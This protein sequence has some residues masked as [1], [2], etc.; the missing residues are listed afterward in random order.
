MQCHADGRLAHA[1]ARAPS[2]RSNGPR[3]KSRPPPNVGQAP[4]RQ[5]PCRSR[6][7]SAAPARARQRSPRSRRARPRCGCRGGGRRRS[8]CSGRSHRAKA[9]PRRSTRQ[10]WRFTCSA[11]SV[12]CTT[13]SGSRPPSPDP[14]AG[15]ARAPSRAALQEGR[16]GL[17]VARKRGSQQPGKLGLVHAVHGSC[18]LEFRRHGRFVTPA[19]KICRSRYAPVTNCVI[20]VTVTKMPVR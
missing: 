10:V 8:A 11:S 1:E 3:R 14:A 2:R 13:S 16:I 4:A 19:A 5:A 7:R 9:S 15:E 18:L 6:C 12:S 17:L 20:H